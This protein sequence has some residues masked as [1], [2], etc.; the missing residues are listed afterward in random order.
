MTCLVKICGLTSPQSI[1]AAVAAGADLIGLVF[2]TPSPRSLTIDAAAVLA[3]HIP[4]YV[5]S[6]ALSVDA[7]DAFLAAIT[8][9]VRPNM[10]QLHGQESPDR[11]TEVKK[12]C[13]LPVMKALAISEPNDVERALA[14]IDVADRLMFD[15]KPAQDATRPGGN[16]QAFD[17]SLIAPREWSLPWILAGGLTPDNVVEA[18]KIS[19][20][21]A[22]DVSSGVED[23]IGIKNA[24]KIAAF[25]DAAKGAHLQ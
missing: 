25:I 8:R 3:R 5:C 12:L 15:A 21:S 23:G 9:Q 6:V 24:R 10:M 11:V 4:K 22:V 2:F 20:A 18:I 14:Y 1:D 7:D 17:W 13:G 19:G 16:A